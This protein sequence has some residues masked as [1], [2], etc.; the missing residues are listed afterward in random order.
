M[1]EQYVGDIN[2]YR[3]Y[4]LLRVLAQG[5]RLRTGVCWML[6]PPDGR[7]DGNK[8]RYLREPARWRHYDPELFDLLRSV[9]ADPGPAR[10]RHIER[11]GII[12]AAAY[13]NDILPDD[14]AGRRRFFDIVF[15]QFRLMDLI[16][17]DP[18]NGLEVP[19]KPKGH[20]GSSKYIYRDEISIAYDA[21]ASIL[22]Y[23]HFTREN[24]DQYLHRIG[25]D[26]AGVVV[27]AA[28][29][30]FRTPHVVFF[31]LIHPRHAAVL[32]QGARDAASRW[33]ARFLTGRAL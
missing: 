12:P 10:L 14:K 6:T 24:R 20:K 31:L 7:P 33:D 5:G 23:Q 13:F 11:S 21:G 26:L 27:D 18:D 29:W 28:I 15:D 19:S 30:A 32:G 16:F 2:D 17:L 22:I 3:K 8:T 9:V 25:S 4:A 1:K